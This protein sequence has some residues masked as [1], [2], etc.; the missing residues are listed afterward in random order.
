VVLV[1]YLAM[2]VDR[3]FWVPN[4]CVMEGQYEVGC[5]EARKF[6]VIGDTME[7]EIV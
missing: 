1:A 4:G 3:L 7:K 6:G 5:V 2:R